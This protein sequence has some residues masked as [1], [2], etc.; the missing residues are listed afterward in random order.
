MIAM[1]WKCDTWIWW[2]VW[3]EIAVLVNVKKQPCVSCDSCKGNGTCSSGG[4]LGLSSGITV[5]GCR[6]CRILFTLTC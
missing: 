1:V 2:C 3:Q 5:V 6:C 4:V